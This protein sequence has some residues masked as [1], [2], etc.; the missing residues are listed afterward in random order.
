M[1]T[2]D[3]EAWFRKFHEGS[4]LIKGWKYRMRELVVEIPVSDGEGKADLLA[5]LGERIG[6]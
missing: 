6:R 2:K 5:D 4:F 1:G 3:E